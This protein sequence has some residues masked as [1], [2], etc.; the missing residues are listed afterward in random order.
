MLESSEIKNIKKEEKYKVKL[1][2]KIKL[3]VISQSTKDMVFGKVSVNSF[4]DSL[5]TDDL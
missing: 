2:K 3:K 4:L 1:K 5:Q